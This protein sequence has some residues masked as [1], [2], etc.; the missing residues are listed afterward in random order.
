[1]PMVVARS[2]PP[3][4]AVSPVS[5]SEPFV[6]VAVLPVSE[7]KP[8]VFVAVL[9]ISEYESPVADSLASESKPRAATVPSAVTRVVPIDELSR[10]LVIAATTPAF[11]VGERNGGQRQVDDYRQGGS[12]QNKP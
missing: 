11:I 12:K 5:E 9:P 8:F 7:S 1:M 3:F 4:A 2:A 6:F 10:L